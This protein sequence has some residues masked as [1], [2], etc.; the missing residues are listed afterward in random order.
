M[1]KHHR[2]HKVYFYFLFYLFFLFLFLF[3]FFI[4]FY[5]IYFFFSISFY[6]IY[7][8]FSYFFQIFS[9]AH[10]EYSLQTSGETLT[11][12]FKSNNPENIR[13]AIDFVGVV[14]SGVANTKSDKI[15][16][17]NFYYFN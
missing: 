6:F 8:F 15:V 13:M 10:P 16:F 12:A 9:F 5:F 11:H 3:F 2:N 1:V 17:T 7:F 14:A 4:S